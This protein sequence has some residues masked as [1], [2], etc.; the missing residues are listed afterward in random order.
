LSFIAR[1]L[2]VLTIS[3][4]NAGTGGQLRNTEVARLLSLAQAG[5]Q[6]AGGRIAPDQNQR[7]PVALDARV[8]KCR[9]VAEIEQAFMKPP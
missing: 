1:Q 3:A 5:Q 2:G 7:A 8:G 6:G 9:F 4:F